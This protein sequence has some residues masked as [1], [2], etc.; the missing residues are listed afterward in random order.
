[1]DL[2]HSWCE[3]IHL[4]D[5]EMPDGIIRTTTKIKSEV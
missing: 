5:E 2:F 3:E 1:M 4:D